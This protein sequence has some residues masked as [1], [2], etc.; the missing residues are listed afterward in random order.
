MRNFSFDTWMA[1]MKAMGLYDSIP[2]I[3]SATPE[4]Y[5]QYTTACNLYKKITQNALDAQLSNRLFKDVEGAWIPGEPT[6]LPMPGPDDFPM[7]S[8][9]VPGPFIPT[10]LFLF[11]KVVQAE[12][13]PGD[14][15]GGV[16]R[17]ME[18]LAAFVQEL[19]GLPDL[20]EFQAMTAR[21]AVK[22]DGAATTVFDLF[23]EVSGG[24]W[25]ELYMHV[26]LA[27]AGQKAPVVAYFTARHRS[28]PEGGASWETYGAAIGG[29]I[30]AAAGAAASWGGGT[31]VGAAVGGC[32]GGEIG[33]YFD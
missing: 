24:N 25:P 14:G 8:P 17:D 26:K 4:Q 29:A 22:V 13:G 20:E 6:I 23:E 21:L 27:L 19:W 11:R 15:L 30:G 33:A 2:T 31:Y 16:P 5:W 28:L 12:G 9:D 3:T 18:E 1:D 32:V 10:E 7:P